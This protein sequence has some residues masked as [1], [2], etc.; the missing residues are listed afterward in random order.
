MVTVVC[1]LGL[2][3]VDAGLQSGAGII[4]GVRD[5]GPCTKGTLFF[6]FCLLDSSAWWESDVKV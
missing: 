6:F 3:D 5:A 1:G 4:Q 2:M